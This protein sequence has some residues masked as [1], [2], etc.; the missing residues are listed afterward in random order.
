MSSATEI[1]GR[2]EKAIASVTETSNT[3]K[4]KQD[5]VDKA[6]QE[7]QKAVQEVNTLRSELDKALNEQ[8]STVGMDTTSRVRMSR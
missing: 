6:S 7:N 5:E 4:Q 3:L 8:L 2:L 1:V